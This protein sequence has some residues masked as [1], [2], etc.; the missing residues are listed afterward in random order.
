MTVSTLIGATISYVLFLQHFLQIYSVMYQ[1]L[2]Q[3]A[4]TS[5]SF[6]SLRMMLTPEPGRF[7]AQIAQI[8]PAGAEVLPASLITR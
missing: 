4:L 8:A 6:Q 5:P 3:A 7:P 1:F 2:Q